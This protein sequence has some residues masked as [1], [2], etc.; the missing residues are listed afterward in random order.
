MSQNGFRSYGIQGDI[1]QN[2][3]RSYGTQFGAVPI[4]MNR[5]GM[6]FE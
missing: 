1:I 4:Y 6:P 3:F 5:E 2:R